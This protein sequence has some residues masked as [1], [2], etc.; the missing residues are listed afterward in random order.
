MEQ[1]L[2]QA[3]SAQYNARILKAEANL[4]N[5]FNNSRAIAEHPDIV[6]EMVKLIDTIAAARGS[7]EILQGMLKPR[8]EQADSG[9][10]KTEE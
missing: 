9:A 10:G 8:E 1:Q 5:Y 4:V 7:I 2:I 6:D 3:I